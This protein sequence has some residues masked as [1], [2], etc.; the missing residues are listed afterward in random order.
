MNWCNWDFKAALIQ[1]LG[2][3]KAW[4]LDD[5]SDA[6]L[7]YADLRDADLRYANID[8]SCWPLW[9]GSIGVKI[10]ENQ[11]RQLLAHAFNVAQPYC[12]PTPKQKRFM[13]GWKRIQSG[14]FPA[15]G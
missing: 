6:D 15:F 8:F 4:V 3:G 2:E 7:R 10:D 1:M 9:C 5:L 13:D 11:A 14:E 12:K